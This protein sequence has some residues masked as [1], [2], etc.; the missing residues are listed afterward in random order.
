MVTVNRKRPF[1][2][3]YALLASKQLE[4]PVLVV[5]ESK[6]LVDAFYVKLTLT[7][8]RL[9]K[10]FHL[11]PVTAQRGFNVRVGHSSGR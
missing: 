7:Q 6:H 8:Q 9:S 2:L 3:D 5:Q 10:Y 4:L 1:C 11:A